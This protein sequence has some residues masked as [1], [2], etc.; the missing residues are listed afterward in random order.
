MKTKITTP[1]T[2]LVILIFALSACQAATPTATQPAATEPVAVTETPV[3]P[4]PPPPPAKPVEITLW[5][6]YDKANAA[7]LDILVGEFNSAHPNIKV[8]AVIQPSY[9]EY[10]TLLKAAI[11]SGTTPDVATVDLIWVPEYVKDGALQPLDEFISSDSQFNINDFY[12]MLTNYDI[13]DGKRYGL[14]FTVNNMQLIWN[15]DLFTKSGLDPEKP[16]K[17]WD[18]MKAMA[19]Q[20]SDPANGVV[21]FEFFTQ[22][23]GEGVTWQFQVWLWAAGG[24]FLNADNTKAA[25]NSPEGLKALTFVSD[26]L[27]GHGSAPGPWGAF[28]DQKACMQL[29]GSWLFGY[30][31]GAPFQWGIAP[32]PAPVG[33][34]TASN[35]GGEHIIMFKNSAHKEAVWEFIKFLTSTQ[36]QLRFDMETGFLPI[37]KSVG[38]NQNYLNWVNVTE[39]RM[40]PFINGMPYAH[41]RPATPLYNQVSEAF[42]REI[43][44]ALLGIASPADAL[45]AAEK[46][47]NEVLSQ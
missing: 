35:T 4:P 5:H 7:L 39:P 32:V 11:L 40:L 30:R 46:A 14:P 10:K 27:Q 44:K 37:I 9:D 13:M 19:E 22:P 17:T 43:Q 29:D 12:P 45:S 26:M 16:P 15:K 31:K 47:V 20:C 25:F 23:P 18:E 3:P 33:G 28:G 38:E 24:E 2:I 21:G 41:T 34:K 8:T 1:I 42:A 36:T 6:Q